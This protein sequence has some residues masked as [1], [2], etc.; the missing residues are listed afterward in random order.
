MTERGD[1][2][3]NLE[4]SEVWDA[5]TAAGATVHIWVDEFGVTA[6]DEAIRLGDDHILVASSSEGF[7]IETHFDE[8]RLIPAGEYDEE[9]VVRDGSDLSGFFGILGIPGSA[10]HRFRW[11]D[12]ETDADEWVEAADTLPARVVKAADVFD[13]TYQDGGRVYFELDR[14]TPFYVPSTKYDEDSQ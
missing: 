9:K 13:V 7:S 4:L 5:M 8:D 12:V 1:A 10:L 3:S 6:G 11:F 14:N 2:M